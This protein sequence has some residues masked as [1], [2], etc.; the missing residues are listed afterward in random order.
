MRFIIIIFII[1]I[2][3]LYYYKNSKNSKKENFSNI[4]YHNGY[5]IKSYYNEDLYQR[6]I[7]EINELQSPL[8]EYNICTKGYNH[9]N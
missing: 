4:K 6:Y 2:I 3:V 1:I 7:D 8:L 9:L 5:F